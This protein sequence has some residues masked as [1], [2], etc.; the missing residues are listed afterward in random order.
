MKNRRRWPAASLQQL[1]DRRD[2]A[3]ADGD[4][5]LAFDLAIEIDKAR[6]QERRG[7]LK[8]LSQL[9]GKYRKARG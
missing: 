5:N 6:E 2:L 9:S 4:L 1:R 8:G 7:M 3:K